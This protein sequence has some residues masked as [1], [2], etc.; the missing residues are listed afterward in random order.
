[1]KKLL[2]TLAAL[3]SIGAVTGQN[4]IQNPTADF[5]TVSTGDNADAFDMTPPPQIE[6]QPSPFQALWN[7]T[8]LEQFLTDTYFVSAI[9]PETTSIDEQPATTSNGFEGSRG[10]KLTEDV[11]GDPEVSGSTRR[12]YQKVAVTAETDYIFSVD[13]RSEAENV[14]TE[15]FILNE[16]IVTEVGL[17]NGAA[18]SRVDAFKL[19]TDDFNSSNNDGTN[20]TTNTLGFTASGDFVVVYMRSLSSIDETTEV[21]VD[22]LSLI[23]D[24]TT[25]SVGDLTINGA[26]LQAFPVP[27]TETLTIE[28]DANITGA[29]LYSLNGGVVATSTEGSLDVADLAN[30]AYIRNRS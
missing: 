17:E 28:G 5:Y 6:G 1:M 3:A 25:L 20:F 13:T 8:D 23:E 21:F 9:D 15:I 14:N 27:M 4:L 11:D 26:T 19:I 2:L 29:T 24:P 16:E 22:N 10:L 30:G 12:I 7:N 18:D